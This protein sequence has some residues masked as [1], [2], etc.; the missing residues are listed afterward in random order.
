MNING[1]YSL[2]ENNN[3][4]LVQIN[5]SNLLFITNKTINNNN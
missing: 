2:S 1:N 4:S 3:N 5:D